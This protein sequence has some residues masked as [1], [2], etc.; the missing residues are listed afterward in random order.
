MDMQK[1]NGLFLFVS[2]AIGLVLYIILHEMGHCIVA[3]A[4]G[5]RIT[6][7]SIFT[8][9]MSYTGGSFTDISDLWL[10][11]NGMAF[12]LIVSYVYML[13]YQKE[14][15][16]VFYRIFSYLVVIMPTASVLAWVVIPVVYLVGNAPVGDDVTKFLNNFCT[17]YSPVYVTIGALVLIMITVVLM[18]KKRIIQN[19]IMEF[20]IM[21]EVAV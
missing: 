2:A 15:E 9:H 11:A 1:R 3:V 7:F 14:K 12:P 5:A 10:H 8:A 18:V 6:E 17:R 20:R 19:A 13:C 21:G 4:C 16:S